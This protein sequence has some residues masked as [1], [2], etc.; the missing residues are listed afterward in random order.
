MIIVV[1]LTGSAVALFI[2]MNYAVEQIININ[3]VEVI[4][5]VG[6]VDLKNNCETIHPCS[7]EI[8]YV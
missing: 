2:L 8:N 4:D 6:N 5:N 3:V 7:I 1:C